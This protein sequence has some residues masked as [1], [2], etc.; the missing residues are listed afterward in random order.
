MKKFIYSTLL[1]CSTSYFAPAQIIYSICGFPTTYAMPNACGL[2]G[3]SGYGLYAQ[4]NMPQGLFIDATGNLLIGDSRNQR[5]RMINTQGIISTVAGS[6]S[7]GFSGDSG[8]ATNARLSLPTKAIKDGSGNTY[9]ADAGNHRIRKVN[10]SG[11]ITTFAGTGSTGTPGDGGPA[12][13][14]N[15]GFISDISFDGSGNLYLADRDYHTIRKINSAG[16]ISTIAG[17]GT[18]G[19][20]GDGG[21]ATAAQ[22]ATPMGIAID[23]AGNIF[24]ASSNSNTIRKIDVSGTISTFAGTGAIGRSG[25]GGPATAATMRRPFGLAL[26]HDGNLYVADAFNSRIRKIDPAGIITLFAGSDSVGF[27]GDGGPATAA[28]MSRPYGLVCNA[29]G[30]LLFSSGVDC[31]VREVGAPLGVHNLTAE[32]AI[33][34]FPNPSNGTITVSGNNTMPGKVAFTIYNAVGQRVFFQESVQGGKINE[35]ISLPASTPDGIYIL[36]VQ[37]GEGVKNIRFQ[38]VR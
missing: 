28:R 14:A 18:A 36:Q 24:I 27:G 17:T 30:N 9:I 10:A 7:A 2:S 29:Y 38:V 21:P 25:D 3:D 26:D 8:P 5:I 11:I 35:T 33:S 4:L 16:T 20:T 37:T 34:V 22:L 23:G 19:A 12:T 1:F 15:F 13:A 32:N 6:D 31:V